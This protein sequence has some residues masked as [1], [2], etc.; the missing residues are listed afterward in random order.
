MQHIATASIQSKSASARLSAMFVDR[1][2]LEEERLVLSVHDAFEPYMKCGWWYDPDYITVSASE[3]RHICLLIRE[4]N[5]NGLPD[6]VSHTHD[7][8]KEPTWNA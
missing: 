1:E 3:F 2:V 5:S 7:I 6:G 8:P 4:I